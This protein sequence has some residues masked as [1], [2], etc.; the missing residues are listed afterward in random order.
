MLSSVYDP[1]GILAPVILSARKIMQEL[2]RMR[3]GWDE[4]VPEHLA[5]RRSNSVLSLQQ[6]R[7]FGLDRCFK[8]DNFGQPVPAQL[9]HFADASEDGFGTATYLI[10]RGTDNRVH[11]AFV[12]GKAR[13]SPLKHISIPRLELTAATLAVQIDKMLRKELQLPLE[14]SVFWTDSTTVLKYIGNETSRFHTFVANRVS[15]IRHASSISQWHSSKD[16]QEEK[17][18][19][20]RD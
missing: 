6:L 1:L 15:K 18:A 16:V 2:C 5:Q 7:D 17:G 4:T 8:P 12:F 19:V 20:E 11:C 14:D 9:H 13:V 3:I 10:Q